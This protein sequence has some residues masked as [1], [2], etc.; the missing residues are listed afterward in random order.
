M[1]LKKNYYSMVL[2]VLLHSGSAL[3]F[4]TCPAT[5]KEREEDEANEKGWGTGSSVHGFATS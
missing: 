3:G 1:K 2:L 4:E 5:R